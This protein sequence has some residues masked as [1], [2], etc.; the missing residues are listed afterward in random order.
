MGLKQQAAG[1]RAAADEAMGHGQEEGSERQR[2]ETRTA[3]ENRSGEAVNQ[4]R[5]S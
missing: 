4:V 5:A 2:Q 3:S 1:R